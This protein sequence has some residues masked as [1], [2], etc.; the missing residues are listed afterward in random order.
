MSRMF[1]RFGGVCAVLAGVTGF[2][3]SAAFIVYLD[4]GARGAAYVDAVLLLAG[5]LLSAVA[6]VAVYGRVRRIDEG[7]ALL[8]LAAALAASYGAMTH[9]AFDLANLVKPPRV[10]ASD[11]PSST[12]PRGLGTFALAAVAMIV[13]GTLA[14]RGRALPPRLAYL[15]FVGA[16]LLLVVF[17]GRLVILDPHSPVLHTAAVIDGFIVNPAWFIWVGRT[18]LR[19]A[20]ET[21]LAGSSERSAQRADAG[22]ELLAVRE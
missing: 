4:D 12:D 13:V 15:A 10:L 14:L 3:Y 22:V 19:A 9:G 11:L 1:E 16:G 20:D 17:V 7:F 18:L 21:R 8:G 5:G 6:F 2:G